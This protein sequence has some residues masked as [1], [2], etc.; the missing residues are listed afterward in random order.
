MR[1][2]WSE[3]GQCRGVMC[4]L[5]KVVDIAHGRAQKI[6]R[7]SIH[8]GVCKADIAFGDINTDHRFR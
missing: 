1:G 4:M 6:W 8:F 7:V 3:G 5:R 2:G